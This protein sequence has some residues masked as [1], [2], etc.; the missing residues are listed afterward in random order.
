MWLPKLRFPIR[1][2]RQDH[3]KVIKVSRKHRTLPN[4]GRSFVDNAHNVK[5]VKYIRFDC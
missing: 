5:N 1:L 3:R 2:Q 4:R